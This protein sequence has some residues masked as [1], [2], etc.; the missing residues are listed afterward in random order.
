MSSPSPPTTVSSPSLAGGKEDIIAAIAHYGVVAV[1]GCGV[2]RIVTV[3]ALD[4][5]FT[6]HCGCDVNV[7]AAASRNDVVAVAGFRDDAIIV[8]TAVDLICSRRRLQGCRCRSPPDSL[9]SP[10]PP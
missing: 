6:V 10:S 4:M 7:V 2:D 5:I 9:S 3:S 1:A 8:G